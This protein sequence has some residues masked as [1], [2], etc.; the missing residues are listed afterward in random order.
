M[1]AFEKMVQH[2]VSDSRS[3][4]H[5]RKQVRI[6]D[7][8]AQARIVNAPQVRRNRG[9]ARAYDHRQRK[10]LEDGKQIGDPFVMVGPAVKMSGAKG[11]DLH[12]R[13]Q[14]YKCAQ[15]ASGRGRQRSLMF[16]EIGTNK[17]HYYE[18]QVE[19]RLDQPPGKHGRIEN[20]KQQAISQWTK[21]FVPEPAYADYGGDSDRGGEES[22]PG[23]RRTTRPNATAQSDKHPPYR[24]STALPCVRPRD[25]R[26]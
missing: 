14:R 13:Y 18:A 11:C 10:C 2:P 17:G 19:Q 16:D 4:H 3:Q 21:L 25:S 12:Y 8:H 24:I 15:L 26:R 1:F 20:R 5:G 9:R 23:A 22:R 6:D 7:D